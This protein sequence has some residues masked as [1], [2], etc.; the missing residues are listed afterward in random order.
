MGVSAGTANATQSPSVAELAEGVPQVLM[1]NI[2]VSD[3]PRKY[4]MST[5]IDIE[6]H[7]SGHIAV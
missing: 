6:L 7:R 2:R 5:D 3:L 1:V 4:R